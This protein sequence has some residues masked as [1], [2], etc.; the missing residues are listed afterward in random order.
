MWLSRNRQSGLRAALCAAAVAALTALPTAPAGATSAE[1]LTAWYPFDAPYGLRDASATGDPL[2]VVTK[3][4][5]TATIGATLGRTAVTFPPRCATGVDP[6]LCPRAVLQAGLNAAHDPGTRPMRYG[7]VIALPADR[8]AA[9]ENIIQKG[10][11]NSGSQWKLQVDGLAGKPSCVV[12][13]GAPNQIYRAIAPVSVADGGWHALE[14]Q[15]TA[16]SL[17]IVVDQVKR[18]TIAIPA[19]LVLASSSPL[20][21]GGK[22]TSADNDQFH[23]FLDAAWEFIG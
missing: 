18:A 3:A 8:T 15:R 4:G 21:I 5:G 13:G 1:V 17:S 6:T 9:G 7:A 11:S 10:Y 22:G 16:T 12:A 20:R 14:C 23:G 2:Q 19:G